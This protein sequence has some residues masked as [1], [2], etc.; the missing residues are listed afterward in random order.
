M[1]TLTVGRIAYDV[2]V[3]RVNDAARDNNRNVTLTGVVTGTV[4]LRKNLRSELLAQTGR[5]IAVTY[6]TDP[7][8]DGFYILRQVQVG[9][10][11]RQVAYF[12]H[13]LFRITIRMDRLGSES[14]TEIQSL[15]TGTVLTNGHGLVAAETA[16]FHA[17]PVGHLAY[18]SVDGTPTQRTRTGDEGDVEWYDGIDDTVDPTWSVAPSSFYNG[19]SKI[20]VSSILRAGTDA[21]NDVDDFELSNSLVKVTPGTTTGTSNGRID[22]AFYDGAQFDPAFRFKIIFDAAGGAMMAL[23]HRK[24]TG[25]G[26]H[27]DVSIQESVVATT[28]M[29]TCSWD[30]QKIILTRSGVRSK[31]TI[32]ASDIVTLRNYIWPCQDGHVIWVFLFGAQERW[33]MP[34]VNWI[35]SEGMAD[36][37]IKNFDWVSF[38]LKTASEETKERMEEPLGRFFMSHTKAELIEGALKN[39]A[40]LYPVCTVADIV[41]NAQLSDRQLWVDL[42]HP[43]LGAKLMYPGGF[44]KS[45]EVSSGVLSRAPLIG[46][47]N[48][49]IF[50]KLSASEDANRINRPESRPAAPERDAGETGKKTLEGIKVV[51]FT[52][53]VAGPQITKTLAVYGAE[54]IKI[55]GR[56]KPDFQRMLASFKD[57]IPG[58]NRSG[59]WNRWNTGTPSYCCGVPLPSQNAPRAA[60]CL[61]T[62]PGLI[63]SIRCGSC[64]SA[65]GGIRRTSRRPGAP[66]QGLPGSSLSLLALRS[67]PRTPR[68]P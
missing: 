6:D 49:E 12:D 10:M 66:S 46:E 35:N 8:I 68:S 14:E 59:D 25:E 61:R 34:L 48:Q 62:S 63:R 18:N 40:M 43:E 27:V 16:P 20:F 2:T 7:D 58:L 3:E 41:Q 29:P 1:P 5:L 52:W 30:M 33:I 22:V 39:R 9:A 37:F 53:Y 31:G 65:V 42:E 38:D 15:I 21:P 17:P 19:S 11:A 67:R 23:H 24:R 57:G 44:F 50:E 13:G 47:H 28:F 60:P 45:T 54:V 26:Q 64:A 4:A 51:D 32:K 36:D 56:S 55:E